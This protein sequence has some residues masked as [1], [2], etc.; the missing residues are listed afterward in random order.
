MK[1]DPT[2]RDVAPEPQPVVI[3]TEA[4]EP[5]PVVLHVPLAMPAQALSAAQIKES[6]EYVTSGQGTV[7]APTATEE[8][9]IVTAGQ[10]RV[11]ILWEAVQGIIAI[12]T[13]ATTV[14]VL[15]AM[16]LAKGDVTA[17]QLIAVGQL[18]VMATLILSFYFSRTN[19]SAQGGVGKKP[20][21]PYRGR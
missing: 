20:D 16:T 19:H 13:T 15:A 4:Q 17:N 14:Y 11:N 6:P 1:T 21:D 3:D 12:F 5:V 2:E 10:R 7:A 18:V 8:E 9:Q